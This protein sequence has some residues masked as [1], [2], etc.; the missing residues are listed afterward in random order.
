MRFD[1]SAWPILRISFSTAE[2]F[3]FDAMIVW[4][5]GQLERA[6]AEDAPL[7]VLTDVPDGGFDLQL[8]RHV[9]HWQRSLSP[10]DHRRCR[11]S[12][13]VASTPAALRILTTLHW[14]T[15]PLGAITVVRDEAEG[16]RVIVDDHRRGGLVVPR[17]PAWLT[18]ADAPR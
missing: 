14:F 16:W 4:Y 18:H 8:L 5:A 12:V 6:H 2:R 9:A 13:V 7:Y 15:K 10:L 1:D 3:K 11:L 17:W